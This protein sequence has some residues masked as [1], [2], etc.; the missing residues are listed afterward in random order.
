M[1]L[2]KE[3]KINRYLSLRLED[4][5]TNI[6]VNGKL[7]E[8]CKFLLIQI[9][10]NEISTFDDIESIDEATE[11]LDHSLEGDHILYDIPPDT[12]FWGH[13]SNLQVWAENNYNTKLL[14]SNLAFPLLRKLAKVG[15][16]LANKVLKEEVAKRFMGN[17]EPVKEFLINEGYLDD[18]TKEE[19][20]A[21][22]QKYYIDLKEDISQ[23]YFFLD[24]SRLEEAIHICNK[25]LEIAPDNFSVLHNL[26]IALKSKGVYEKALEFYHKCHELEPD[27]HYV[28][29]NISEIYNLMNNY[30]LSLEWAEKAIGIF[31]ET[32]KAY[33]YQGNAYLAKGEYEDAISAYI[34]ALDSRIKD[35]FTLIDNRIW[36]KLSQAYFNI[37]AYEDALY[38]CNNYLKSQ[39]GKKLSNKKF[40]LNLRKKIIKKLTI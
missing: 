33:F 24:S 3:Y 36:E 14:H 25:I 18:F 15:D 29:S 17:F 28:M 13:C 30:D 35:H 20:E 7:F 26:G 40:I 38:A 39:H 10:I 16:L 9:P 6:Y 34:L 31:P 19:L 12:I 4:N 32:Y 5:K 8:T 21:I 27:D 2:G 1:S 23:C 22:G 11:R 37:G